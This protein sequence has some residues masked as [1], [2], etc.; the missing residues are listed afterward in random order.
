MSGFYETAASLL[1]PQPFPLMM[2][3][4]DVCTTTLLSPDRLAH[5]LFNSGSFL[6]ERKSLLQVGNLP[7][8]SSQPQPFLYFKWTYNTVIT[9]M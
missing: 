6:K 9:I 4:V 1:S 8:F 3:N 2:L 5:S 7:V